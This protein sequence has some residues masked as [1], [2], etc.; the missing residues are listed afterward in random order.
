M[1]LRAASDDPALW[2]CMPS[3]AGNRWRAH[4]ASLDWGRVWRLVKEGGWVIAGQVASVLGALV[5]VRVLT[6][7]LSPTQYGE[8]ALGLTVAGLISQAVMG[9]LNAGIGRFY[10]IAAEAH[11]LHGYLHAARRLMIN[12]TAVVVVLGAILVVALT[13][14]DQSKWIELAVAALVLSVASGYNA[15]LSGIQNAARQRGLVAFH[16]GLDAWLKILLATGVMLW[17]GNTSEA[18]VLG[19]LLSS[20]LITGSQLVL[21]RRRLPQGRQKAPSDGVNWGRRIWAYSWPFSIFGLFTWVHLASDRWVLQNF[22]TIEEVGLY[23]VVYQLGYMPISVA[24]G[25]AMNFL[26]PILY[27]RSG[28]ATDPAR[29]ATVHRMAWNIV[30]LC[31]GTTGMAFVFSFT[32]HAEIFRILVATEYQPSSYLLPWMVLAGGIFATGQMLALKLI[33]DMKTSAMTVAKITTALL[34]ILLNLLGA[35]FFGV[36]GLVAAQVGFSMI[37]FF[38]MMQLVPHRDIIKL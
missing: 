27:Q 3:D 11:D 25:M 13:W 18:V 17:L 7:Y 2:V 15:S 16:G 19:Y 34:G 35:A 4:W 10:A 30:W 26:G 28:N 23:A 37:Y 14:L 29:N 32:L 36:I 33:T 31:I 5:L 1:W 6:E 20:L 24:T 12:A 9:G 21:V 38:W 8:L 22:S